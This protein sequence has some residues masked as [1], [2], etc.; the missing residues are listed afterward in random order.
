MSGTASEF[1]HVS[2]GYAAGAAWL[3]DLTVTIGAGEVLALVRCKRHGKST[4]LKL[5]NRMS[6]RCRRCVRA[7]EGHPR[8][9]SDSACAARSGM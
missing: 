9:G 4:L 8:M 6:S 5:V 3:D 1:R 2:F 7:G